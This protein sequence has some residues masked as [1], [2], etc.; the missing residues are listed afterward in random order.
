MATQRR[1]FVPFPPPLPLVSTPPKSNL[2][3][4]KVTTT[5]FNF[6]QTRGK[7][8]KRKEVRSRR[9]GDRAFL[10]LRSSIFLIV[11]LLVMDA[12]DHYTSYT[13]LSRKEGGRRGD[14]GAAYGESYTIALNS[15]GERD[16]REAVERYVGCKGVDKVIVTVPIQEG[17][18]MEGKFR[19]VK[20]VD[21]VEVI[22][23][24]SGLNGRFG[25]YEFLST[26]GVVSVDDDL[27][28]SCED[29]EKA[30]NVW[31]N[32]GYDVNKGMVGW[33]P[34]YVRGGRYNGWLGVWWMGGFQLLLTKGAILHRDML[35]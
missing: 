28:V 30:Y 25:I 17:S 14:D 35:K 16:V 8:G 19:G 3:S 12:V 34:R 18:G 22:E 33:Y 31:V 11:L 32:G 6:T 10:V 27:W 23:T 4:S 7:G 13:P 29:V 15:K 24:G 9:F 26:V 1:P 2:D 21:K 5:I 20:D